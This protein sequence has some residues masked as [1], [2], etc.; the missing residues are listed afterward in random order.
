MRGPWWSLPGKEDTDTCTGFIIQKFCKGY[1]FSTPWEKVSLHGSHVYDVF[2]DEVE[3]G[4]EDILGEHGQGVDILIATTAYGKLAFSAAFT[5]TMGGSYDMAVK[6][7]QEKL[8]RGKPIAK[9]PTIQSRAAQIA[10]NVLTAKMCLY[11]AT[12]DADEFQDN[13]R[14]IKCSTALVKGY[15]S[16]LAVETNVLALNVHGAYGVT[17][18]YKVERMVR[19]SLVAPNIEGSADIQRLITGG[20]I[21]RSGESYFD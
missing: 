4:E 16:D 2:R 6:Y 12:S 11:K 7:A 19:D 18:E 15:I 13:V 20:Y 5:S 3:V 14:K 8:H 21:L 10:A 1:S 17:D 9:F